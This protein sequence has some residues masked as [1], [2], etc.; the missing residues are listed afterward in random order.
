MKSSS[1]VLPL[2]PNIKDLNPNKHM[3]DVVEQQVRSTVAPPC[4]LQ[5]LKVTNFRGFFRVYTLVGWHYF[6]STPMTNSI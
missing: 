6:V 4:N 1:K 2:P 5:D 3:L